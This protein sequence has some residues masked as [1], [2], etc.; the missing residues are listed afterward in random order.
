MDIKD[1]RLEI[2]A[3]DQELV[4]VFCQRMEV[5]ARIADYKREQ[6]LPIYHPGREQEVLQKVTSLAGE[7]H[8]KY[9]RSIYEVIFELSKEYQLR[10]ME[11]MENCSEVIL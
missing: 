2:D 8:G 10:Y 1:L 9:I 3:I 11:Q 6:G 4:K 5:A 7:K